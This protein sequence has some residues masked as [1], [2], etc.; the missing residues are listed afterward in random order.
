[1]VAKMKNVSFR[2]KG[3][4][5]VWVRHLSAV[6]RKPAPSTISSF[7]FLGGAKPICSR[8]HALYKGPSSLALSTR[9]AARELLKQGRD[10][11]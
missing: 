11:L 2:R 10:W 5:Q 4:N 7:R 3:A 9:Q 6:F 8:P 1:M